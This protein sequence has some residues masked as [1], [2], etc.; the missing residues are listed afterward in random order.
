MGKERREKSSA[1]RRFLNDK[2][3]IISLKRELTR[4]SKKLMA[5]VLLTMEEIVILNM[6]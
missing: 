1:K 3:R 6:K 5:K 4:E 2:I